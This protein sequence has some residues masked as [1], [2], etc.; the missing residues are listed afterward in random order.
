MVILIDGRKVERIL[1]EITK[2]KSCVDRGGTLLQLGLAMY[3][4]ELK[5]YSILMYRD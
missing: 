3:K 2:D 5:I 1:D 4:L